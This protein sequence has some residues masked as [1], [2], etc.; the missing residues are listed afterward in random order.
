M[1]VKNEERVLER[2]LRCAAQ[3]CDELIVVDTGSTDKTIE[4]ARKYSEKVRFFE[5]IDDF[6]AARNYSFSLAGM[7]YILWLD[8]DDVID[9]ENIR[10]FA[11]LKETLP[12]DTDVVMM[13]YETAFDAGGRPA[14][15][16][17]RERL[18]KRGRGFVWQDPVHEV[19]TPAGKIVYS[20]IAVR[21]QKIGNG[22]AGRN[23]AIYEKLIRTGRTL[24]ARQ[25]FYYARELMYNGD[26]E[27]AAREFYGFLALKDAW[28]ENKI[29]ACLDLSECLLSQNLR[30]DALAAL[31]QSF[32]YGL[33]RAEILCAVGKWF[34]D[35]GKYG[36]AA[37]WYKLAPQCD[38][39]GSKQNFV[40][41][42]C[43]DFIPYLQLCVCYDRLG[44]K[45]EAAR[46]NRK[47]GKIKPADP[48][49]LHNKNYFEA[50]KE[51]EK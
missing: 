24:S 4:I 51:S 17:Y 13:N 7:D 6:S 48:A 15:S 46:W 36:E 50:D 33:P 25:R 20:D 26:K 12:A 39:N 27:T 19:I 21:H 11:A 37:Y 1:I 35:A 18:I 3:I 30:A 34:M 40:A 38:K 49:Y 28:V 22:S 14:C 45:T 47:A 5:W 43:Y 31:L 2:V 41:P 23:L 32:E 8:A 16:Y 10:K 29:S 44:D 42:D 9:A